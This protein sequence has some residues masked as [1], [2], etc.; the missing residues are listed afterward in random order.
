MEYELNLLC[1]GPFKVLQIAI[2]LNVL[3][4]IKII[5]LKIIIFKLKKFL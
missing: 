3:L 4:R 1:Y 2:I 5:K